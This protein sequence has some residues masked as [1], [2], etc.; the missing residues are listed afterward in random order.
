MFVLLSL[1]ILFILFSQLVGHTVTFYFQDALTNIKYKWPVG[2]FVILG[3]IQLVSFPMQYVHCSMKTV[4]IVYTIIL[5]S[6]I[7]A[8]GF[9]WTKMSQDQRQDIFKWKSEDWLE[10]L[11]IGGFILFNFII[12]FST[13]SLNDT[14]ADQ[15]FYI[16]LVENNSYAQNINQILPLSGESGRLDSLYNYQSFYLFLSYIVKNLNLDSVLIMAWF[17]PCLI[18]ITVATTFLNLMFY[19]KLPKKCWVTI[20]G[21]TFLWVYTDLYDYFVRYNCYGNN[22]RPFVFC[23]LMIGYLEYFKKHNFKSL[24]IYSFLW[25]SACSLQSTSLFLGIMLMVAYGFYELFYHRQS[26]IYSLILSALPLMLYLGFFLAYRS[27]SV[28]G[29][30]IF[31]LIV[32][33]LLITNSTK[34]KQKLSQILYSKGMRLIIILCIV[35]VGLFS[36]VMTPFLDPSISVSPRQFINF[37]IDKYVFRLEHLRWYLE[38]H[39]I[40][41][42]L[43]RQIFLMLNVAALIKWKKLNSSLRWLLII[44]LILIFIFYNPVMTGVVSTYI[45]GIV[46]PRISDIIMSIVLVISIFAYSFSSRSMKLMIIL[47]TSL[48]FVYLGLKTVNYTTNSFN[49]IEDK[50]GYNY[51]YRM[52]QD[53]IDAGEALE[54][55]IDE[56]EL[57]RPTVLMTNYEIS[58]FAHNYQLPYTVYHERL[59]NDETYKAKKQELY[60]MRKILKQSYEVYEEEQLQVPSLLEQNQIDLIVTTT[61]VAPWLT[62]TLEE[63][64]ILIYE[65]SSYQ[66]YQLNQ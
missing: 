31:I 25:L 33:L 57:E 2:F 22:I 32:I 35:S 26:L 8:V 46:Y 49:I 56:H 12:C 34:V 9:T 18:W 5:L 64:G 58:Y 52:R 61:V 19:F 42:T 63:I 17:V 6:L 29:Y 15:S 1:I 43:M 27:S 14:N 39:N 65:N 53:L 59:V 44:Q 11:L 4:S 66:I 60:K 55:Y 40:I 7:V 62:Q 16:T 10:Y 23:Y 21:F 20:G 37:L 50:S 54:N 30:A 48:S 24:C 13:N 36:I 38:W 28:I 51:L 41:L 47:A 3:L 45:T